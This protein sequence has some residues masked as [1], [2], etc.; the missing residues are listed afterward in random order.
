MEPGNRWLEAAGA[1]EQAKDVD[2][3]EVGAIDDEEAEDEDKD[4]GE[5]KKDDDPQPAAANWKEKDVTNVKSR[6]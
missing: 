1:C 4:E 3:A 5:G 2:P 6:R